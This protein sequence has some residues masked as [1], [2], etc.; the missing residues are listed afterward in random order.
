MSH[1]KDI[2][3]KI[4]D[5]HCIVSEN[6]KCWTFS[7]Y[8]EFVCDL[9]NNYSVWVHLKDNHIDSIFTENVHYKNFSL[10]FNNEECII[11]IFVN[12]KTEFK[13]EVKHIFSFQTNELT[14]KIIFNWLEK[15]KSY[16]V[17]G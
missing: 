1:A 5:N 11:N 6:I 13:A 9:C 16:V 14:S 17:Y 7:E 8:T 15:F 2:Y 3:C 4:C 12:Y 10:Q